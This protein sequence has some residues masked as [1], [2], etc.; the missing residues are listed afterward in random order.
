MKLSRKHY[1]AVAL[2]A[3][4]VRV[5]FIVWGFCG[6]H[7]ADT[8]TIGCMS[9]VYLCQ[10]YG[11]A[12][13]YGYNFHAPGS[14]CGHIKDLYDRVNR[15][16]FRVTPETAGNLP[17]EGVYPTAVHPPGMPLLV[18]AMN[19]L[20]QTPADLPLQ[21]LGAVLD[22][23]ATVIICWLVGSFFHW[24]VGF[25]TGILYGLFLPMAYQSALAKMPVGL[26]G[27]FL[28]CNLACVLIA[29]RKQGLPAFF[30]YTAAGVVL[31]LGCYL[32]PDYLL[33]PIFLA[34]GLIG[35]TG[36]FWRAASATVLIQVTALL[37]LLPW[38]IRNK[39]VF[40]QYIFTTSSVGAVC[41]TGL[42]EF[43]NPWGIIM[44]DDALHRVAREHGCDHAWQP[45]ANVI[46]R[47]LFVDCIKKHPQAWL[48]AIAK[49]LPLALASPQYWGYE[50][51]LH[52]SFLKPHQ[53]SKD[54]YDVVTSH[55]WT[56]LAAYWDRTI[57]AALSGICT[58]CVLVMIIRHRRQWGLIWLLVGTHLYGIIAHLLTH[59]E[60]RYVVASM[61]CWIIGLA[62][63]LVWPP[64]DPAPI[65]NP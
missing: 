7:C 32:R 12:A 45:Q 34:G 51:P 22:T 29:T 54:R 23:M 53:E 14:G 9:R 5:L 10:G 36:S 20:F 41:Y 43:H 62:Y 60:S 16:G 35:L 61:F 13:G 19:R 50:N 38:A 65:N 25:I 52:N 59:W 26:M 24:R 17:R 3:A 63:V 8:S 30:W 55:P 15:Q 58:I 48:I 27:F 1:L 28:A 37:I 47:K 39:K 6:W 31:G 46:F 4:A 21:I 2:T 18:A 44:S 56:T 33:L 64:R 11:I 49:R 57:I 40:D 42:G